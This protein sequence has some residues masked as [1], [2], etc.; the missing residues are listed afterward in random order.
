MAGSSKFWVK[1]ILLMLFRFKLGAL[2]SVNGFFSSYFYYKTDS[3]LTSVLSCFVCA[4]FHITMCLCVCVC[5]FVCVGERERE[6]E[7]EIAIYFS[8]HF[9][10]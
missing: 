9:D 5:V 1:G 7:R 8:L 4:R 6:R 10:Y 3:I 2:C